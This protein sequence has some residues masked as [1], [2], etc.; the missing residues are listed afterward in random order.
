MQPLQIELLNVIGTLLFSD[1]TPNPDQKKF[2][3]MCKESISQ[4]VF[5]LLYSR[6]F[7]NPPSFLTFDEINKYRDLF[8]VHLTS[9]MGNFAEHEEL[10]KLM[11]KNNIPYVILKGAASAMYYKDPSLRSMGDVDFLIN[12]SDIRNAGK[13]VESVGFKH[14]HGGEN[15]LHIAFKRPPFS[16]WEMHRTVNGIP[17]TEKGELI[18]KEIDRII[19]NSHKE[20]FEDIKC[21]V[22]SPFHH[23]LVMLLHVSSHMTSEGIGLRHICDW[24]VFISSISDDEFNASFSK[25]LIDFGL[26]KFTFI[27]TEIGIRYLNAP[28][29]KWCEELKNKYNLNDQYFDMFMEDILNSGNFGTKDLNRYREIKYI[30]NRDKN[31]IE[32]SGVI[33]SALKSIS[34]KAVCDYKI[35]NDHRI[36]LP[37]GWAAELIKYTFL[38]IKGERKNTGTG[39]MLKEAKKR[40]TLYS[41]LD[42]F[43]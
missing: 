36:L 33:R 37:A 32:N 2:T 25:K 26:L 14:D 40:K 6:Y 24:S 38:L 8:L 43:K 34:S 28:K 7:K 23:G 15:D 31:N 29:K 41:K 9:N 16:I 30:S 5:P 13:A 18:Q 1:K 27:L 20:S 4:S 10:D 42:L 19:E 12:K 3:L 17:S 11:S 21:N 35:I 39:Q 22:P